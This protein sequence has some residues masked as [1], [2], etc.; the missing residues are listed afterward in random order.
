MTWEIKQIIYK[1]NTS[2]Q[3]LLGCSAST[4]YTLKLPSPAIFS[5]F[6]A[7]EKLINFFTNYS[8][9]P[10]PVLGHFLWS[11]FTCSMLISPSLNF[12]VHRQPRNYSECKALTHWTSS[13]R[14]KLVLLIPKDSL[15]LTFLLSLKQTMYTF[16]YFSCVNK[17]NLEFIW[18][19]KVD[20]FKFTT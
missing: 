3:C 14:N 16:Q 15:C 7:N 9:A 8:V 6:L 10:Q 17:N 20:L 5:A 13:P 1:N 11:S 19:L 4:H 2:A 18:M 12:E